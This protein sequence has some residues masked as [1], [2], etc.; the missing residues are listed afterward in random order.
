MRSL[1][2][3]T[4][5]AVTLSLVPPR[6]TPLPAE[7]PDAVKPADQTEQ[8]LIDILTSDAP[9]PDKAIACKKLAIFGSADAVEALAPLLRDPELVSWARIA[10]EAIPGD[11][12]DRVLIDSMADIQGRSLVGVINTLGIR[13]CERATDVLLKSLDS[14]DEAVVEA[15]AVALGTIGGGD[16]VKALRDNLA[17]ATSPRARSA[18]AQGLVLS[19]EAAMSAG[20]NESAAE[21]YDA[22]AQADVP[23]P[24][25]IE[26]IRGSI[27]AR[28]A[29]GVP[30]LIEH[31]Q[32]DDPA[33]RGIVLMTA[34]EIP[35]S[36][37]TE[38]LVASLGQVDTPRRAL[39]LTALAER[40]DKTAT[41]AMLDKATSDQKAVRLAA[42]AG[43]QRLGDVDSLEVLL[44]AAADPDAEIVD[45]ALATLA[46]MDNDELDAAVRDALPGARGSELR[47]LLSVV[48]ARR[49]STATDQVLKATE[50]DDAA[51][52]T[53]AMQALGEIATMDDLPILIERAVDADNPDADAALDALRSACIRMP[54]RDACA[55]KLIA[56]SEN[57]SFDAKQTMLEVMTAMGG[58]KA[59]SALAEAANAKDPA[60]QDAATRLL[61]T[62]MTADAA[63]VLIDLASQA[64]H[65]Y[66]I[67]ALRGHLRIA[68]QFLMPRPQRLKMAKE[69][70][71]VADRDEEKLLVLD[72]VKR[73][74]QPA[75][76][77]LAVQV[78]QSPSMKAAASDIALG[79]VSAIGTSPQVMQMLGK[80]W[81]KPIQVQILSASYGA[82]E[83]RKDVTEILQQHVTGLPVITMPS[84]NYNSEFQGDPAPGRPKSLRVRYRVDGAEGESEF[85]ENA[86]IV[87]RTS[88]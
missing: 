26:S 11:E 51:T 25:I 63:P 31:L 8:P 14:D 83:D 35:G 60:M 41:A 32:S 23:Q 1:P 66:R 82:G 76:L 88:A 33:V 61:G 38:G 7:S 17:S 12:A 2:F 28:E 42:I 40:G 22:I 19:A 21:M 30:L 86:P 13:R 5:L 54:D 16:A 67:R 73:N 44:T 46:E 4:A 75:M 77:A 71:A 70:L 62:W 9:K 81:E 59:L 69:A 48:A 49:I 55:E 56:A 87:L 34:R 57:A 52:R 84:K 78:G 85:I 53:A 68:R 39:L 6:A 36:E 15:A 64:D 79:V 43:L 37:A 72:V 10:L 20:E 47:T 3:I 27:L 65:P 58:E 45:A 74:P 18:A 80:L 50:S 24:R 29:A